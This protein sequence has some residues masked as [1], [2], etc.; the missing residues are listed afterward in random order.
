[1]PR[2]RTKRT[3]VPKG[4]EE[5]EPTLEEFE[6]RMKEAVVESHEGK[7]RSEAMWPIIK[8]HHQRSRYIYEQYKSKKIDKKVYDFCI[9]QKYADAALIAKWK[10]SGY[11]RLCC[12]QCIQV[13]DH[14]FG[15]V[16]ICRV[17]K[18][19]L[20]DDSAHAIECVKC[21]CHG[22]ASGD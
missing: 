5:L 14:S 2:V 17:P 9:R 20:A 10:K 6:V 15:T 8:I 1:M 13:E 22:C 3:R 16:C 4:F 12:M 19:K 11:E 7:R 18:S 21:G